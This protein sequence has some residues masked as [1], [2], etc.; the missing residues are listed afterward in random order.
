MSSSIMG[1]EEMTMYMLQRRKVAHISALETKGHSHA[2]NKIDARNEDKTKIF[3]PAT[4][5]SL[6]LLAIKTMLS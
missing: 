5:R 3:L 1:F 2:S 6:T 4:M